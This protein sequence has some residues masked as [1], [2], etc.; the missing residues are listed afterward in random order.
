MPLAYSTNA[1]TRHGLAEAIESI[2][3]LGFD[4]VEILCD[5][6]HWFL[7]RDLGEE[8]R[9]LRARL[10]RLGLAV[11]NL[12][13]NTANGFFDPRPPENVF[14]PS[15]ASANPDWRRW[16]LDYSRRA[17][18]L[19]RI[20]G[21]GNISVTSGRPD[22]GGTPQQSQDLLVDS[23]CRLCESAQRYGVRVGVEYEPGLL[24]ER[25]DELAEVIT[26]VGSPLLGANL[27]L[28]HSW[29]DG[30]S[31]EH[32]VSRLAGRIWNTHVE[33][34]QGRKHYHLIPGEGELPFQRYFDA[35]TAS[36]YSGF[37]T[38]ELYTYPHMAQEA[39][40]RSLTYLRDLIGGPR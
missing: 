5:Q 6:P 30:E 13:C 15:L 27:D 35:L 33:D 40:R 31:P 16:R 3:A 37:H 8:A 38:V 28:G 1:Y 18:D 34:I 20:L 23:L 39:G 36:G 29:L 4:G 7:D 22:T 24:V 21:A 26:R 25:A 11:S 2:A 12:N 32:A 9:H 14:E 19:A 10:D 17:L